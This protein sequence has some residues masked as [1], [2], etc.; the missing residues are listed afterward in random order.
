MF[1][2][3]SNNSTVPGRNFQRT[4]E[5]DLTTRRMFVIFLKAKGLS[6]FQDILYRADGIY[7]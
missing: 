3:R 5:I 1:S 7:I 4:H 6:D 2:T